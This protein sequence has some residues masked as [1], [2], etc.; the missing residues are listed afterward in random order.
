M[1]RNWIVISLIAFLGIIGSLHVVPN[2]PIGSTP[3][4]LD[5]GDNGD[6]GDDDND[7]KPGP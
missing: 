4:G 3:I 7:P 1:F 6:G 2:G 5:G